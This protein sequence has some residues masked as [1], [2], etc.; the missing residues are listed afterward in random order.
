MTDPTMPPALADALAHHQKGDLEAAESGYL[1]VIDTDP[2]NP[3]A[4]HLLSILRLQQ[5]RAE[6]ALPLIDKVIALAPEAADA[7]GNKGTALQALERYGEAAFAFRT[8]IGYAPDAA[9]HHYNLGNTLRADDDKPGAVRAYRDAIRCAPDL[10]QAHS[11]LATTL[12]EL[13]LFDEAVAHCKLALKYQ[14]GFADAHY[15]LGNA[16][17]EAG[18]YDAAVAAYNDALKH[19]PGHADAY[20]NLG[21]TEMIRPGLDQAIRTLGK[22]VD[23]KPDH[24]MARFYQAVATEMIGADATKLF[25]ALPEDDAAV[26]AWLDSWDYVK[27]HSN[28]K[29]EIIHCPYALL[30]LALE[31]ASLDGLV[32]E[33]GVRHGQSIRHIASEARQDTHGFDSF[34]GLPSAWGG[35]PEGVYSTEGQLPDVPDNV[36]LHAGLFEDTLRPFLKDHPGEVRFCNV[37]CDIYGSTVTVLDGLAPRIKAGSVLVF[38]E[39]LINPTWRDDEYKAF[40]EAVEKYGWTYRYLAFGI[41]TKQAAVMIEDD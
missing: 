22:A 6:E 32:L 26:D 40:Q 15:N 12:S 17:R 27:S 3:D 20:C 30:S 31:A 37:D 39:Y 1:A 14:P 36:I 23:I 19:D 7:Y 13:G 4:H 5:G 24:D 16:H 11:N 38:D 33:F 34:H 28:L 18:R 2:G 8:A 35:E 21:L 41:V 29:T 9:H 25:K 10:V